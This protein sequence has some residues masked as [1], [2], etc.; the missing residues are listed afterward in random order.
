MIRDGLIGVIAWRLF[1]TENLGVAGFHR[2][3]GVCKY[4]M[5]F[6][7]VIEHLYLAH[8]S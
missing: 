4:L 5:P 1:D 6:D 8:A 3:L 2:L 7:L